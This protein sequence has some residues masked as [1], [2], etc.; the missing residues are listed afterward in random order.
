M[1]RAAGVMLNATGSMGC[2]SRQ[3]VYNIGMQ[4]QLPE[5]S[6]YAYQVCTQVRRMHSS[7]RH[8]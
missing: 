2:Y 3:D 5:L 8:S 7:G 1:G 6:A 4:V